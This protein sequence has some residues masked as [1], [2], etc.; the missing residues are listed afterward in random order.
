MEKN[1]DCLLAL[2]LCFNVLIKDILKRRVF[3][4]TS[5]SLFHA[6]MFLKETIIH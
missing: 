2:G 5:I 1:N 4:Y 3:F 6:F